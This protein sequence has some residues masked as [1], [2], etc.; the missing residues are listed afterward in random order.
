VRITHPMIVQQCRGSSDP[1]TNNALL[2]CVVAN[3][4]FADRV[5]QTDNS[6]SDATMNTDYRAAVG[7]SLQFICEME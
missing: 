7:S 1:I 3:T 5:L 2:T 6:N 4:A